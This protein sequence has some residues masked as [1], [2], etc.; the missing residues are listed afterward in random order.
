M[1]ALSTAGDPC[2]LRRSCAHGVSLMTQAVV[3]AEDAAA[4]ATATLRLLD[5]ALICEKLDDALGRRTAYSE[6]ARSLFQ[7]A[8]AV[9]SHRRSTQVTVYHLAYAL[10]CGYP[11]AGK[12]LAECLKSDVGSFA[13]GCILR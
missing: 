2:S 11:E 3:T 13:V 6:P 7:L 10:V 4:P 5:A 9:A 8:W 12:A 1:A